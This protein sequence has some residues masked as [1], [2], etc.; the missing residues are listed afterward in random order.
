MIRMPTAS[1]LRVAT[2]N[3][4]HA[5]PKDSY[6][7]LPDRLAESCVSLDA[8]V[9][10]L[11]EVDVGVPRSRKANLAKV[12]ADACGMAYYFA[13]AR[14]HAY[15]GQYG[16]A[17]LVRGRITDVEVVRLSGDHRHAV[18]LGTR[19]LKPFRERRNAI[20]ATVT[21]GDARISVG[22]GHFAADRAA[23]RAQLTKTAR[24]AGRPAPRI[25]LGDFNVPWQQAADWLQPYRLR[26][27]EADLD[28]ELRTGIDHV[29][30]DGLS[31]S[32]VETRWLP[33]SDHPAKIVDIDLPYRSPAAER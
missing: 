32:C 11:Q 8:D 28:A 2:F 7:G 21:V 31:V 25:L 10:A 16:N 19:T 23:R 5:A 29:A 27:A 18:R 14:K 22:T 6:T 4:R 12:A 20:I 26:L 13:K 33:I 17:L 3:I 15:R 1:R 24:L 30:V 9:L